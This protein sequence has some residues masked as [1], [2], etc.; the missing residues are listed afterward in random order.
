MEE[1]CLLLEERKGEGFRDELDEEELL[2]DG[3][4]ME[5]KEDGK[6]RY[7]LPTFWST[8]PIDIIG[9]NLTT[10]QLFGITVWNFITAD[11]GILS[12]ESVAEP[13]NII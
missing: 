8:D 2:T 10:S 7:R 5:E 1:D 6:D 9:I 4:G 11:D 3:G 12:W 13:T